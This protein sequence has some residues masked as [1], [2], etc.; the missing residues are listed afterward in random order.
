MRRAL[1]L[2]PT[3]A[4]SRGLARRTAPG[5]RIR[6]TS[7]MQIYVARRSPAD[8]R[9]TRGRPARRSPLAA[10]VHTM[11]RRSRSSRRTWSSVKARI[12]VV[13]AAGGQRRAVRRPAGRR[14]AGVVARWRDIIVHPVRPGLRPAVGARHPYLR[15]V[16]SRAPSCRSIVTSMSTPLVAGWHRLNAFSKGNSFL[17]RGNIALSVDLGGREQRRRAGPGKRRGDDGSAGVDAVIR[18]LLFV[19]DRDGAR[20][21]LSDRDRRRRRAA[22]PRRN[23][24]TVGLNAHPDR[25]DRQRP[26]GVLGVQLP[27]QPGAVGADPVDELQAGS[28]D[29]S[30]DAG[31]RLAGPPRPI[32]TRRNQIIVGRSPADGRWLAFDSNLSGN[33]DLYTIPVTGGEPIAVTTSGEHDF[34]PT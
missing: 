15:T 5:V 11:A 9:S 28:G 4:R 23:L 34:A 31:C 19:S 22:R 10:V 32:T 25:A 33:Q 26:A 14:D 18:S 7:A 6:P 3:S 17:L 1:T 16:A 2:K 27:D 24:S 20:D 13:P 8:P 29:G 30:G 12:Y 21:I